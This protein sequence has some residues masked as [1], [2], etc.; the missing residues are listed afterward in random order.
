M[1]GT[2]FRNIARPSLLSIFLT[3]YSQFF[4]C[5]SRRLSI[6]L[7]SHLIGPGCAMSFRVNRRPMAR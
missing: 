1:A 3:L 2:D 6:Y 7:Y 5:K 4:L